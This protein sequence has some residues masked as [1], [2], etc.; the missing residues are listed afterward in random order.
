[1]RLAH[2]FL[3]GYKV[4]NQDIDASPANCAANGVDI[5]DLTGIQP[6]A[7]RTYHVQFMYKNLFRVSK[8]FRKLTFI[9]SMRLVGKVD[10][11][12]SKTHSVGIFTVIR[13]SLLSLQ[14]TDQTTY[15]TAS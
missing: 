8:V 12:L 13:K 3:C 9:P 10:L 2:G 15:D 11:D 5:T 14:V 6:S 4:S 7:R 1:M